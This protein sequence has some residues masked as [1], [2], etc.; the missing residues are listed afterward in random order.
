MR[1]ETSRKLFTVDEYHAMWEAGIFP[2]DARTELL[3]GEIYE[4]SGPGVLHVSWVNR[5]N[6]L[7]A[8]KLAGQAIVSIQNPL[9]ISRFSEPQPDIV[10]LKPRDD[11]YSTER[12]RW[13][14]TFLVIEVADTSLLHDLNRKLPLYAKSGVPEV[15]IED[16]QGG[17]ILVF[18]DPVAD[19]YSNS[20]VLGRGDSIAIA[21]FPDILFEV[22]EL[23]G[24]A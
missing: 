17:V 21:A 9:I 15:W 6:M 13:E 20:R 8:G 1:T 16:V 11:Y 5:A 23:I 19:D 12:V 7:L 10:L 18:Q 24:S 14:H 22:E 4:M 2:E 3:E